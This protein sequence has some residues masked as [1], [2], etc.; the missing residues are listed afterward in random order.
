VEDDDFD[1][2]SKKLTMTG[3]RNKV[4]ENRKAFNKATSFKNMNLTNEYVN[5]RFQSSITNVNINFNNYNDFRNFNNNDKKKFN[6]FFLNE[7]FENEKPNYNTNNA[8]GKFFN[9]NIKREK[10]KDKSLRNKIQDLLD[11]LDDKDHP[12]PEIN[13]FK[14]S[15]FFN[16][17][18]NYNNNNF[19]NKKDYSKVTGKTFPR[20]IQK[21]VTT[22]EKPEKEK[23]YFFEI[24]ENAK[25]RNNPIKNISNRLMKYNSTN[26]GQQEKNSINSMSSR[27]GI[28]LQNLSNRSNFINVNQK[29][30]HE[31]RIIGNNNFKLLEEKLNKLKL[32]KTKSKNEQRV[33]L[34]INSF[35]VAPKL[36]STKHNKERKNFLAN[37]IKNISLLSG[38]SKK[39]VGSCIM[40]N[41]SKLNYNCNFLFIRSPH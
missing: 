31:Y 25:K 38:F 37:E 12:N 20:K 24:F 23:D 29:P 4:N 10:E 22:N 40:G 9:T 36:E 19:N 3:L 28:N 30:N 6:F 41:T 34:N 18:N 26:V 33:N 5:N 27:L 35:F 1:E 16:S 13:L 11:G 39:A 15:P 14:Q 17:K 8:S 32:E 2:W 7:M 21:Q